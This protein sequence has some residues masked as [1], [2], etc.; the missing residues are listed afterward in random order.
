MWTASQTSAWRPGLARFRS[1]LGPSVRQW[2]DPRSGMRT[3]REFCRRHRADDGAVT[4][5]QRDGAFPGDL[6]NLVV[7]TDRAQGRLLILDRRTGRVRSVDRDRC[8]HPL[9]DPRD[10]RR[11]GLRRD[12]DRS[13][14]MAS[15]RL[16]AGGGS[17]PPPATDSCTGG[18]RL[19]DVPQLD[20][21]QPCRST[22]SRRPRSRTRLLP[23]RQ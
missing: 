4:C 13:L 5:D 19:G 2:E 21:S 1:G 3:G 22:E 7:T 6:R 9:R 11:P 10:V 14:S 23:M 8:D 12:H 17:R 16:G 15:D 20:I 18:P